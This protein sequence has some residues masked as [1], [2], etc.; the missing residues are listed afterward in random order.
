MLDWPSSGKEYKVAGIPGGLAAFLFLGAGFIFFS[1]I[2]WLSIVLVAII[3][4]YFFAKIKLNLEFKFLGHWLV[5][6][7]TGKRKKTALPKKSYYH[8]DD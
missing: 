5:S 4:A 2:Y 7:V 3:I 8:D 6:L 1:K